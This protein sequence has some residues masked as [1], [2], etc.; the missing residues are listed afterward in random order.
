MVS[1]QAFLGADTHQYGGSSGAVFFV[2]PLSQFC[3][4]QVIGHSGFEKIKA[5]ILQCYGAFRDFSHPYIMLPWFPGDP[6]GL[7]QG[8]AAGGGDR[9]TYMIVVKPGVFP[10]T[11]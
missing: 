8:Y 4:E 7:I 11:S 10:H 6:G 2:Q 5:M 3:L 9:H 1:V